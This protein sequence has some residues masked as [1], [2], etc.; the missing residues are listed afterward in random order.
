SVHDPLPDPAQDGGV[1]GVARLGAVDARNKDRPAT[2]GL[3]VSHLTPQVTA[4]AIVTWMISSSLPPRSRRMPSVCSAHYGA[5]VNSGGVS[6]N[7][8]G[9][10]I[11]VRVL[12]SRSVTGTL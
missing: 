3:Y 7:C 4:P 2:L 12:P 5:R 11:S 9:L 6:S 1:Q 10:A 8:S